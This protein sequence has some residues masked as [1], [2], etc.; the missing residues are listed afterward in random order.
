MFSPVR[1]A[2]SLVGP[3]AG[4]EC[5]VDH[6]RITTCQWIDVGGP[7]PEKRPGPRDSTRTEP[8]TSLV[9][10]PKPRGRARRP[11]KA[12]GGVVGTGADNTG[13]HPHLHLA[14]NHLPA[15]IGGVASPRPKA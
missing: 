15:V 8:R 5:G 4:A 14:D 1:T 3:P 10:A 7:P 13:K 12:S 11:Q 9:P 6:V 2:A